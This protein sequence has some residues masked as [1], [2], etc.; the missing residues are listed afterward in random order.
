MA[1]LERRSIERQDEKRL[2]DEKLGATPC[3]SAGA[4]DSTAASAGS[5]GCLPTSQ[6]PSAP[7]AGKGEGSDSVAP[8]SPGAALHGLQRGDRESR[9]RGLETGPPIRHK[10]ARGRMRWSG[11]YLKGRGKLANLSRPPQTRSLEGQTTTVPKSPQQ[12][13]GR[14]TP[15]TLSSAQACTNYIRMGDHVAFDIQKDQMEN[16]LAHGWAD[17]LSCQ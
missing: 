15:I 14:S 17:S 3:R 11:V 5:F 10:I 1:S 7:C 6:P 2:G 4:P 16:S 13:A 12:H 9:H 8:P